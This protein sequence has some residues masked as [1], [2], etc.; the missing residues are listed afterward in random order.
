[1]PKWSGLFSPFQP[2]KAKDNPEEPQTEDSGNSSPFRFNFGKIPD[3]KT[4][5]P[6]MSKPSTGP[7][8]NAPT[9]EVS[10][11]DP[12]QVIEAAQLVGVG[13]VAI[14]CDGNPVA[15]STYNVLDG[16]T[17]FFSNLFSR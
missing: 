4:L 5:V 17:S 6:V 9:S 1:M 13:H 12:L 8:E 16:I 14:I 3:V 7:S 11:S 15:A 10:A 2:G